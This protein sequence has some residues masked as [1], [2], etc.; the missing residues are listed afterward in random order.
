MKLVFI[1]TGGGRVNLIK[2]WRGTGGFLIKGSLVFHIDPGPGALSNMVRLKENPLKTDV[3]V[4]THNHIDH[5]SDAA[6]LCE[7]MTYYGLK[8]RGILIGSKNALEGDEKGDKALS[9]YHQNLPLK[10][11]V[12]TNGTKIEEKMN[13]KSFM[14]EIIGLR[15]D[16]P[17]NFGFKLHHEGETLGYISDTEYFSDLGLLFKECDC[18]VINNLKPKGSGIPDH[19]SSEDTIEILK[20]AKPNLCILTHLG[21]KFFKNPAW[22]EA[23]KITDATGVKTIAAKDGGKYELDGDLFKSES[24]PKSTKRLSDFND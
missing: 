23:Q 18:L 8:K 6:V 3:I 4:V 21:M 7:A 15:H 10:R 14:M 9:L 20:V 2:Q 19:L 24:K 16:E 5:C 1:G 12:A 11:I 13:S 17:S 22:L